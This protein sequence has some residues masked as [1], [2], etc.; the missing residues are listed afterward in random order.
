MIKNV[1]VKLIDVECAVKIADLHFNVFKG[2]LLTSLG[3]KFLVQFY[4]SI[5]INSNGFGFGA[6]SDTK[7]IGFAIGSRNNQG[8]YKSLIKQNGLKMGI[9]AFIH[10]ILNPKMIKRLIISF[11]GSNFNNYNGIP[12]LLSICVSKA[13]ES[14]GVGKNLLNAFEMQLKQEGFAELILTTDS[15]NN[16]Y[17]NQFYTRNQYRIV[18]SFN[19]GKRLMNLYHKKI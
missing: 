4:K 12:I 8:F 18:K 11:S 17:V 14:N 13:Q 7:L 16:E 1:A 19:Q 2:F 9:A 15:Q 3:K 6:F 10:I 5:L